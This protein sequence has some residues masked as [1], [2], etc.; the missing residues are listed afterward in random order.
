ME[1]VL[2]LRRSDKKLHSLIYR[3]FKDNRRNSFN[4]ETGMTRTVPVGQTVE[5]RS[6]TAPYQDIVE[7]IR[8]APEPIMVFPCH[9]KIYKAD[10]CNAPMEVCLAFGDHASFYM[11]TGVAGRRIDV[12]EALGI[13]GIAEDA[14]L[15][16]QFVN[17]T[18][19]DLSWLCNCCG[20]CCINMSAS[21]KFYPDGRVRNIDPSA[22]I[23]TIDPG[24]CV[25]CGLCVERCQVRALEMKDDVCIVKEERCIGC[26]QCVGACA[27]DAIRLAGREAQGIPKPPRDW[28]EL[29]DRQHK[30]RF[31]K[32]R[33]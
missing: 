27:V 10:R 4:V 14:G 28:R 18:G 24:I 33:G 30:E 12:E 13:L 32:S 7:L 3:V 22:Y 29:I 31:L 17:Y 9:C 2:F 1:N 11:D 6:S 23:A 15:V 16:H 25:G 5:A 20:C 8:K 26:G 21:I 19:D